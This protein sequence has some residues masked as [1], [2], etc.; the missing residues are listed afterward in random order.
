M[1]TKKRIISVILTLMLLFGGIT[2]I[3][4]DT[5]VAEADGNF[6]VVNMTNG[7]DELMPVAALINCEESKETCPH[8]V[9]IQE[10]SGIT[11]P[12]PIC[13]E[14]LKIYHSICQEC[15]KSTGTTVEFHWY[16]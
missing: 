16:H 8:S 9:I 1:K 3:Y 5:L 11:M 14:A 6:E 10:D 15:K 2:A 7:G 12:C 13:Q 4:A